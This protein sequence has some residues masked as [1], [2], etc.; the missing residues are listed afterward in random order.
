MP[1]PLAPLS[2]EP[3]VD[4]HRHV[5]RYE[6]ASTLEEV[7]VRDG[8]AVVRVTLTGPLAELMPEPAQE[9]VMKP[10][11]ESG[12]LFVVRQPGSLTWSAITFYSLPSGEKYMHFGVR[13]TP[14]VG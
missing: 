9:F 3:S 7:F 6:R 11:D 1:L 2:P 8:Q 14:K 5:G 4:L 13:A 12:D 10:A